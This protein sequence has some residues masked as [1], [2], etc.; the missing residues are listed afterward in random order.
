MNHPTNRA[1]SG[2]NCARDSLHPQPLLRYSLAHSDFRASYTDGQRSASPELPGKQ[3]IT[4]RHGCSS[5]FSPAPSSV[6]IPAVITETICSTDRDPDATLEYFWPQPPPRKAT[7][8]F[9][10][11]DVTPWLPSPDPDPDLRLMVLSMKL[12]SPAISTSS[13]LVSESRLA[14]LSAPSVPSPSSLTKIAASTSV[15]N[16][17]T[18]PSAS[19]LPRADL[20]PP[21]GLPSRN[22]SYK[23]VEDHP[24]SNT[25][26]HIST[27]ILSPPPT[28]LGPPPILKTS[29]NYL[30]SNEKKK[31]RVSWVPVEFLQAPLRARSGMKKE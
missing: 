2:T 3:R 18:L 28:G 6:R 31:K 13:R 20:N 17:T 12:Q 7:G 8:R 9:I 15:R 25:D 14:S 16:Q 22:A 4:H 29:S 26:E 21:L 23:R 11:A 27:T 19:D 30:I 10:P 24:L 5:S 1:L